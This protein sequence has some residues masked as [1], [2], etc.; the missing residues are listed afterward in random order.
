[1][2]DGPRADTAVSLCR[3]FLYGERW[4]GGGGNGDDEKVFQNGLGV[5][6]VEEVLRFEAGEGNRLVLGAMERMIRRDIS[7]RPSCL[8][9]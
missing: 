7:L 5:L 2:D 3:T 4:G 1:M 8:A 9:W 6:A